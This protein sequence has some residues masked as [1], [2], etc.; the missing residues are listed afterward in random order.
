MDKAYALKEL[1]EEM[2]SEEGLPLKGANLVFGE[3][4]PDAKVLFI[5]EAPGATEDMQKRPFVGRA[6]KLLRVCIKEI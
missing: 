2:A 1:E 3:G 4:S 5:G 6:G